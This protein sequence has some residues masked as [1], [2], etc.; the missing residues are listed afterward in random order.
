MCSYA[1]VSNEVHV[2]WWFTDA[3]RAEDHAV[4][5]AAERMR[6]A[7][8][9]VPGAAGRFIAARAGLRQHL[10]RYL[11]I[12]AREVEFAEA[13]WGKPYLPDAP[14]LHFSLSHSGPWAVLACSHGHEVGVD[15]E[16]LVAQHRISP[17][18]QHQSLCP[19][20]RAQLQRLP[21]E[22]HS[23]RFTRWW[24]AKEAVMK[25]C[26]LGLQLP[27]TAIE[28]VNPEHAHPQLKMAS[29]WRKVIST[30]TTLHLLSAPDGYVAT[31]ALARSTC[32]VREMGVAIAA[33]QTGVSLCDA[34]KSHVVAK[35]SAGENT[36]PR[37]LA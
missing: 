4:L 17:S 23:A 32:W 19:A 3:V 37:M 29:A 13:A 5:N 10:A 30:S 20:E 8:F 33:L 15:V 21:R 36:R 6:A 34:S 16:A 2:H 27:P 9:I 11:G 35:N 1:A 24:T 28:I 18:L 31:L 25:L 12:R 14:E 26:G 7:R 22:Q